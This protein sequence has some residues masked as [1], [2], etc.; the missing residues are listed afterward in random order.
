MS[1]TGS[2]SSSVLPIRRSK[3]V[4]SAAVL[5]SAV[6]LVVAPLSLGPAAAQKNAAPTIMRSTA[7]PLTLAP[8]AETT[9]VLEENL[10]TGF[11]WR[12]DLSGGTPCCV[13][14]TD[15]GHERRSGDTAAVGAAGLHRWR[16]R[17]QSAGHAELR[18]VYQRHWEQQPVREHLI[19]VDVR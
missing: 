6:L 8:G 3:L 1:V 11:G 16:L 10:T 5:L 4:Q 15:L 2:S 18:F 9:I 14:I 7:A 13:T 19:S 12:L 17:A